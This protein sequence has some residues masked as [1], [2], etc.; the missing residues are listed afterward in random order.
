[1]GLED[2]A[3]VP[4]MTITVEPRIALEN[5]L[6]GTEDVVLITENEAECLTR[7]PKTPFELSV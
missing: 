1:M 5:A 3:L 6:I 7:F 2:L 4:G